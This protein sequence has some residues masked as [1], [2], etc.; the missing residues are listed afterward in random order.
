MML[1]GRALLIASLGAAALL[2][3]CADDTG[4]LLGNRTGARSAGGAD[5]GS[6]GGDGTG[7]GGGTG[8]G[9][10][11]GSGGGAASGDGPTPVDSSATPNTA[12]KQYFTSTV[13]PSLAA[14]CGTCHEKGPGPA[15][16][17]TTS[18]ETSYKM[19]F[20]LGY[21]T[22]QSRIV[23]KGAHQGSPGTTA[24]QNEMFTKWVSMELAAAGGKAP[25]NV[26]EKLGACYDKTKFDAIRLGDMRTVRRNNENDDNCTGCDNAPCRTCHSGDDATGYVNSIGNPNLPGDFTFQESKKISPVYLQKYFG[27]SATGEPIA[28]NA[29]KLKAEAT[30]KDKPY[31]HPMYR[32][33]TELEGRIGAFVDDTIARYKASNG[34]CQ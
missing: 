5:D 32:V 13:Q 2:A 15:W 21:V 25:P 24:A 11:G 10:G 31:T 19:M 8:D 7:T 1:R 16:I 14:S 6:G 28:S 9:T 27:V 20:Q 18:A 33:S 3:A 23:L 12:A 30:Q 22:Q 34:A 26:L 29:L 4:E 17:S